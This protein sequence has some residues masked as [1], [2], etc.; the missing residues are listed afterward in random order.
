MVVIADDSGSM[1]MYSTKHLKEGE[2][3]RSRWGELQ[4]CL[5]LFVDIAN[6][7]DKS[8]ADIF[9]LNREKINVKNVS[10][11]C[12]AEAFAKPPAGTTPLTPIL[13][14]VEEECGGEKPVLLFILTDGA[15][16]DGAEAFIDEMRRMVKKESTQYTFKIQLMACTGDEKS[17]EWMDRI[18]RDLL[19]VD[20]TDDYFSEREQV[21]R[22]GKVD[23]FTRGDWCLKAM[24]GPVSSK[25]DGWDERAQ[26]RPSK[27]TAKST[28]SS[29]VCALL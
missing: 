24:L 14:R 13:R 17:L 7:F 6:C 26:S 15:P 12:F 8:G 19:G 25:F 1:R 18:D 16:D 2:S 29:S 10:D 21:L 20:C 5:S 3:A 28:A 4:D 11:A 27:E 22:T 9:F 23:A